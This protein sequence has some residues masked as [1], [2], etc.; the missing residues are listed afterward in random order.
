MK[1]FSVA[2]RLLPYLAVVLCGIGL[3]VALAYGI[4]HAIQ[5]REGRAELKAYAQQ[6]VEA[7]DQLGVEDTQ[8]IVAVTHDNLPFCSEQEIAF[9]RDY[10]FHSPDIRDIGRTKDGKLYCSAGVGKLA[11]PK[12]TTAPDIATGGLKLNL[13]AKSLISAN[14]TGFVIEKFG[15]ALVLNPEAIQNFEEPP[16]YFSGFLYDRQAQSLK[17]T[18]GPAVPLTMDEVTAGEPIERDGIF[19]QPLCS[20]T[21]MVCQ[22]AAESRG[23]LLARRGPLFTGFLIGGALLGI[24]LAWIAILYY[25]R[26][27]SLERQLRRAIHKGALTI[28]YQ[29]VVNL[30]SGIIVGAE[31]LVRWVDR[32]GKIVRPDLFVSLA[33]EGGYVSDITRLVVRKAIHEMGDLL[34][35]GNFKITLNITAEDLRDRRTF[36]LLEQ[37][38]RSAGLA[39]WCIGLELT[40]R[41]TAD[42]MVAIQ[43][44]SELRQAG[45]RVYIDDF[46]TG[47]SSLS[48]LHR[49]A[50]DAIKIDQSFTQTVG[51]GAVT[52]SVVPLILQMAYEL[53]LMVVVEGIETSEQ[54]EYFRNA[55]SGILAQGW[56]FGQPVPAAQMKW[57]VQGGVS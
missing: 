21:S 34:A 1:F 23:D 19:Y 30:D 29:P 45:H 33:E 37:S 42:Q 8:A 3:G 18:F 52:A 35:T 5:L 6:L 46:G 53:G 16:K 43:A 11:Q 24:A 48:Y 55:G 36:D 25:H 57:L 15:V 49:L 39:P 41:S 51:T 10:V 4:A 40:E 13:R 27:R 20:Q 47:Y 54:A 50:V 28:A 26:Q 38:I 44:I 2:R 22:V 31:A 12:A 17:Q 56:L 14:T 32:S 7:G 9:M